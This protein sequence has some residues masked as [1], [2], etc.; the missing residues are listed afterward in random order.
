MQALSPGMA[1]RIGRRNDVSGNMEDCLAVFTKYGFSTLDITGGAPELNP[2]LPWLL[3]RRHQLGIHAMV[4]IKFN[5][6]KKP[7]YQSYLSYI[8]DNKIGNHHLTA[9]HTAKDNDRQRGKASLMTALSYCR[10]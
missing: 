9:F 6:I 8:A 1:V 2:H 3:Q 5:R 7:E 10:N 4:S